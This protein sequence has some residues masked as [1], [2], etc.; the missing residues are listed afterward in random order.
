[1]KLDRLMGIFTI[2]LQRDRVTAPYLAERFE[3]TRRT[4]GRDIDA[5]C[6]A[7][8]PVVTHRG[9]GGGISIADG[10]KIDKS[11]LTRDELSSVASAL[12]GMC[13]VADQTA[14]ARTLD[15]FHIG[16]DAVVSLRE[17]VVIDLAS[18]YKGN[19]SEKIDQIKKAILDTQLIGFDYYYDKGDMHRRIEPYLVVFQWT[20][21]YVFGYCLDRQDWRLFKLQR[22]WHLKTHEQTFT[23]RE[24]PPEKRDF[25]AQLT[26]DIKLVALFDPSVR[27]QL[28]EAYGLDCY[29]HTDAG[30]RL[31]VGYTNEDYICS[32]LLGF[33]GKA[34]VLEP[35][36]LVEQIR[37]AGQEIV[38][39]Y[40]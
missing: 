28:I 1:M 7:G 40:E 23:P 13:S 33:G 19:L 9:G 21:W 29:T 32:W 24:I 30:L 14:I 10:Y 4:I 5:L 15:K 39:R 37:S 38:D 26:D 22:L 27:Y 36:S 8:I 20:A 11:V 35:Q 31:E 12:R 25:N 3:V 18:H 6:Q 2:L 17:S 34:K 16:D